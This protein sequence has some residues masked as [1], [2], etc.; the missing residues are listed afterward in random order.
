LVTGDANNISAELPAPRDDEP[1]SLRSDIIDEIADHL[2]CA[3][4]REL[5]SQA[6]GG[7]EATDSDPATVARDRALFRFGNPAAIARRLWYDAM[8]ERI[9][10]QRVTMAAAIVAACACLGMLVVVLQ[11]R[12]DADEAARQSEQLQ[13]MLADSQRTNSELVQQVQGLAATIS[14]RDAAEEAPAEW[15]RLQI[16]CVTETEDGPPM[17]GVAVSLEGLT[18]YTFDFP[19]T[20]LTTDAGGL[21]DFGRVHYGRYTV[22][23]TAPNGMKT[24]EKVSVRPGQD[25]LEAYF[26]PAG[27]GLAEVRIEP[28]LDGARLPDDLSAH[29]W[30]RFILRRYGFDLSRWN[31]PGFPTGD[32]SRPLHNEYQP[33]TYNWFVAPDGR[34]VSGDEPERET[35]LPTG[36]LAGVTETVWKLSE[37]AGLQELLRVEPGWYEVGFA[38]ICVADENDPTGRTLLQILNPG[39]EEPA[40]HGPNDPSMDLPKVVYGQVNELSNPVSTETVRMLQYVLE[41]APAMEVVTLPVNRISYNSSRSDTFG[42]LGF[43]SRVS[44]HLMRPERVLPNVREQPGPFLTGV[45][46]ISRSSGGLRVLLTPEEKALM[47]F[48]GPD[49]LY[50]TLVDRHT[51]RTSLDPAVKAALEQQSESTSAESPSTDE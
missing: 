11:M 10:S 17:E 41:N 44:L 4:N 45:E 35:T 49:D 2:Q 23:L 20:T 38:A 33:E 8:K 50:A 29:I 43:G 32:W 37:D 12:G 47:R 51:E 22:R 46:V 40:F 24:V 28:D 36:P 39:G 15:N 27:D 48:A 42:P 7:R 26:C 6:S 5:H 30:Y 14:A 13:A 18:E 1:A 9:M 3:F 21:V 16:R 25:A 31:W 34:L 19:L